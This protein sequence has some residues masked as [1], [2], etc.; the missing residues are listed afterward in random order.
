MLPGSSE[1]FWH[2][3]FVMAARKETTDGRTTRKSEVITIRLDPR[4][5]YL[6]GLAARRQRRPLSS[7]IEWAIEESLRHV[8]PGFE[9]N[10]EQETF[11]VVASALWDV[12]EADRFANLAF[13]Y[14]ELLTHEEQILW[15]LIREFG[16]LWRGRYEGERREW[17]WS[18]AE[19][20]LLKDSLRK[21]WPTLLKI[22]GGELSANV[23][24]S[25]NP[26]Q[27]NK[28]IDIDDEIPF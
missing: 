17:R 25:P 3:D 22:V 6:A 27:N 21:Y 16:I 14:P 19:S 9:S 20:N 28:K 15:K 13:R 4:L 5:K 10:N 2:G 1:N 12:D 11:A 24:P 18:V 26:I 8:H 23:L 7:F